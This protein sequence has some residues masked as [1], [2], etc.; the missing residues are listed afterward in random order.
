M[1]SIKIQSR[2]GQLELEIT[3]ALAARVALRNSVTEDTVTD[4]MILAFFR[5]ASNFAFEKAAAEY[6]ENDV[7]HT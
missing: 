1:R 7:T 4:S 5:E 6:L 2:D 3:P